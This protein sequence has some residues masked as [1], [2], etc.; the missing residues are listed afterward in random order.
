MARRWHRGTLALGLLLVALLG[1]TAGCGS[2]SSTNHGV[3]TGCFEDLR[4]HGVRY[5]RSQR[6]RVTE[7]QRPSKLG[8]ATAL[9]AGTNII[10]P[11][12]N[13]TPIWSFPARPSTEVIGERAYPQSVRR[14]HR[15]FDQT[16]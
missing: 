8:D 12:G 16:S 14:V 5:T 9:C 10:A 11:Y 7:A 13:P 4:F 15:R 3:S 2:S 1:T 6:V